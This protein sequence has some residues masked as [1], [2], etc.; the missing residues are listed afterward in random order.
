MRIIFN[1]GYMLKCRPIGKGEGLELTG[2]LDEGSSGQLDKLLVGYTA[3]TITLD[4]TGIQELTK[5]G[6]R[7]IILTAKRLRKSSGTLIITNARPE[8]KD[9]MVKGGYSLMFTVQ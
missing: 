3:G 5:E 2:T 9:M 1:G 6:L 8:I 7:P 4:F